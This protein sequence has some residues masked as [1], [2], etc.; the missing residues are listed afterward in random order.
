LERYKFYFAIPVSIIVIALVI[1]GIPFLILIVGLPE[2]DMSVDAR[3]NT[4]YPIIVGEVLIQNTGSQP[5]TNVKVDFGEGDVVDLGTLKDKHKI[6]LTP[7]HDNKMESVT[8]SAD[9]NIFVNV[10]YVEEKFIN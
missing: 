6:I 5:L 4:Q 7:P 8:V 10:S 3:I 2:Y 1:A 9:N